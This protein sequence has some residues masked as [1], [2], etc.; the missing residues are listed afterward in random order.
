MLSE[1]VAYLG[2]S[3]TFA[4]S[5]AL[6]F[7]PL[8]AHLSP[9]PTIAAVFQAVFEGEVSWGVVPVEN[10]VQGSVSITLDLLWQ[11]QGLQIHRALVLP[12]RH[13]LIS[14]AADMGEVKTVYAHPQALAQCQRWLSQYASHAMLVPANS[15]T[16]EID[17]LHDDPS[18]AIV[19]SSRAADIGKLPILAGPINDYDTN[20]TRFW[21]VS[22]APSPGGQQTSFGFSVPENVPGALL[23][24]LQVLSDRQ[25]N[26]TRIESRP[27][28]K[29]MGDYVFFVDV[30]NPAGQSDLG[31]DAIAALKSTTEIFK[32]F[33]SYPINE[34]FSSE[35]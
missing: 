26:M 34:S 21:V 2:P 7:Q 9:Y 6:E 5:A 10:S 24:P 22:R 29:S 32:I 8:P 27:S 23:K 13:H 11:L 1:T 17:R 28:K 35:G 15:N 30:E 12:I 33:G 20:C 14:R 18:A 3:G 16:A 19:A 25:L 4:E 31:A